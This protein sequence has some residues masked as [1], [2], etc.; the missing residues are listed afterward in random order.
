MDNLEFRSREL[1]NENKEQYREQWKSI[2]R[3]SKLD[4]TSIMR[5]AKVTE[6]YKNEKIRNELRNE[7]KEIIHTIQVR[8]DRVVQKRLSFLE[9]RAQRTIEK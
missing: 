9:R 8:Q 1:S 3:K 7:Y 2:I 6:I 4:V 5:S